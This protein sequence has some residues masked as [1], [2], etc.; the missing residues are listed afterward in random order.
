MQSQY[1]APEQSGSVPAV[2]SPQSFYELLAVGVGAYSAIETAKVNADIQKAQLKQAALYGTVERPS[3]VN[4]V[5]G[6]SYP[7]GSSPLS[8]SPGIL[9][10]VVGAGLV[11]LAVYA[12]VR[13]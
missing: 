3:N 1:L 11:G 8:F 13:G 6:G 12:A 9:L 7:I 4:A 5:T 2:V 10:L